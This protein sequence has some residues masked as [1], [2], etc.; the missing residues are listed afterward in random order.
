MGS[1]I[2]R[3]P[4]VT[5]ATQISAVRPPTHP[6]TA[7]AGAAS[8][9]RVVCPHC[10]IQNL[11]GP[12]TALDHALCA[13]CGEPLL[14]KQVV[15]LTPKR[16]RQHL[17]GND[18]P[19]VVLFWSADT[20][21]DYRMNNEFAIAAAHL[22]AQ[23]RFCR[24]NIGDYPGLAQEAHAAHPP[25]LAIFRNGRETARWTIELPVPDLVEWIRLHAEL[26]RPETQL[27]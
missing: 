7:D 3:L 8:R 9:R 26:R 6:G 25:V 1:T 18:L 13:R 12:E 10:N 2:T 4:A 14:S 11:I 27:P 5:A 24:L 19:V 15:D 16:Y 17:L 21:Q 23:A 20:Y 22:A